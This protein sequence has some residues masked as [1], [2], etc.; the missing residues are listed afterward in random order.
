MSNSL[1]PRGLWPARLLCPWNSPVKNT[2]MGCHFP[3]QGIF[4]T[5]GA[6]PC[7]LGLLHWQ[8]GSFPPVPPT[9]PYFL[10]LL[11]ETSGLGS[12]TLICPG[13]PVCEST[14]FLSTFGPCY[15][16]YVRWLRHPHP[17]LL[18]HLQSQVKHHFS[19]VLLCPCQHLLLLPTAW[20][21]PDSSP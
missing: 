3:L 14:T 6:S 21:I 7:L 5:Q 10:L 20:W 9:S 15:S 2:E 16:L 1:R 11:I 17:V 8:V 13:Q 19:A 12:S 18:L 4:P